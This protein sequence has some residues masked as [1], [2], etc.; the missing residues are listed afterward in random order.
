MERAKEKSWLFKIEW[1]EILFF[2]IRSNDLRYVNISTQISLFFVNH[3]KIKSPRAAQV[4]YK[5]WCDLVW[6][7]YRLSPI[8]SPSVKRNQKSRTLDP[9]GLTEQIMSGPVFVIHK[10]PV[11]RIIAGKKKIFVN[12]M[13]RSFHFP[14]YW[15]SQIFSAGW[16]VTVTWPSKEREVSR[17]FTSDGGAIFS[18]PSWP[19]LFSYYY[20]QKNPDF[21][22]NIKRKKSLCSSRS[23]SS[24]DL[25]L[26][27]T[28][29]PLNLLFPCSLVD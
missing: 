1:L 8:R 10:I 26:Y 9:V 15:P 3:L 25:C 2:S 28:Q 18:D 21:L 6:F 20:P 13:M 4:V 24:K 11:G 12:Q 23:S 29:W 14:T 22:F 5:S 17:T 16:K 27:Y 7:F 19:K